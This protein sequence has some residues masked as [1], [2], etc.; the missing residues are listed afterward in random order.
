VRSK[1]PTCTT[2]RALPPPS[3]HLLS[4]ATRPRLPSAPPIHRRTLHYRSYPH[5]IQ[6][7][8]PSILHVFNI[9]HSAL[10]ERPPLA[11]AAA[12]A[13]AE[14]ASF[15]A[16]A[17]DAA[18]RLVRCKVRVLGQG[19]LARQDRGGAPVAGSAAAAGLRRGGLPR[20]RLLTTRVQVVRVPAS[21]GAGLRTR[22]CR[23]GQGGAAPAEYGKG[24]LPAPI[25]SSGESK[26]VPLTP[27]L[28]FPL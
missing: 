13:A 8:W 14:K 6:F 9:H 12:A 25:Y 26:G 2:S 27:R 21:P 19:G 24:V 16:A 28:A 22:R 4:T 18:S 11:A 23:A 1:A 15:V 7:S 3:S 10:A 5:P 20:R 17:V